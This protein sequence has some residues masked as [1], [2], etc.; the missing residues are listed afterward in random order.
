MTHSHSHS[1]FRCEVKTLSKSVGQSAAAACRYDTRANHRD[2]SDLAMTGLVNMPSWAHADP[3]VFWKAADEFERA[4]GMVA[5]RSILSF[6]N[7]LPESE[8][9]NYIREW[10]SRNVPNC[11][12]SWAIHNDPVAD[13][14]NPHC[15][16]LISERMSDGIVR[17]PELFF[18]RYNLKDPSEGG[19]KKADIGSSRK[20]WLLQARASW[21]SILNKHLPLDQQ[22]S[23]LS[24]DAR[25]LLPPQPK[26]GAKVLGAEKKGIRTQLVSSVIEDSLTTNKIRCLSFVD[27][28]GR[29]VTYRSGIDRGDSIEITGKV[30]YSKVIDLVNECREKGWAEVELFGTDE[31]KRLAGVELTRACIKI[32]GEDDEQNSAINTK[33]DRRIGKG[34]SKGCRTERPQRS[35]QVGA[36]TELDRRPDEG[37]ECTQQQANCDDSRYFEPDDDKNGQD[38]TLDNLGNYRQSDVGDIASTGNPP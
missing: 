10:L 6:P 36:T 7:Q 4:N 22:V 31:F 28:S 2:K 18:K 35:A 30:S 17:P 8:Y 27:Q 23:H 20:D 11:P 26:F 9:E 37:R 19:C 12:A 24:N 1:H 25:G 13:P 5:R 38:G 14:Q 34:N 21:A 15:H 32:K 3:T 33:S 16:I 29:E